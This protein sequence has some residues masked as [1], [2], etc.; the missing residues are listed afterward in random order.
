MSATRSTSVP[1]TEANE[2]ARAAPV[3]VKLRLAAKPPA[4]RQFCQPS[5]GVVRCLSPGRTAKVSGS[6]QHAVAAKLLEEGFG[7]KHPKTCLQPAGAGTRPG[8]AMLESCGRGAGGYGTRSCPN[9]TISS[10][11]SSKSAVSVR[12]ISTTR[13]PSSVWGLAEYLDEM[14][15]FQGFLGVVVGLGVVGLGW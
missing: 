2:K 13:G 1:E 10:L 7:R 4:T 8:M 12:V 14:V 11:N 5:G 9:R 3:A 15:R 6:P